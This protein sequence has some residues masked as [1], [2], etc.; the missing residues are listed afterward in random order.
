MSGASIGSSA[1]F[2]FP[3]DERGVLC[4]HGFTGTPFEMRWLAEKLHTSGMTV[5]GP[6]LPGHC[7]SIE[8]L[9][10]TTWHQWYDAMSRSLDDLRERCPRVAVIG[11][12]LGGLLALRLARHRGHDIAAVASLA[13]PLF[14]GRAARALI[15][16]TR[17]SPALARALPAIPKIGGSDIRD[18][19]MRRKNP[20]YPAMPMAGILQLHDLMVEV[21]GD[22]HGITCP[23]LI[24]HARHDHTA[25]FSS[26][27]YLADHLGANTVE[28]ITLE[29]SYH[30]VALDV[31]RAR[32]AREVDR[33]VAPYLTQKTA[34]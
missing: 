31:E 27:G 14:L 26:A 12:S 24:V 15:A 4:I 7:D 34:A 8:A 21:R 23:T 17:F 10:Q 32:V 13:A 11:Q 19:D 5:V 9:A 18:S 20:A 22:L 16:A 3:G 29:Q 30:L 28:Q 2:S 1:P 33:F 25:P 6:A